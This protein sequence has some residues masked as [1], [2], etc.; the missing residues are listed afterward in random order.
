MILLIQGL[1]DVEYKNKA[2]KDVSGL[3]V[4]GVITEE[5][6]P[7]PKLTGQ[8]T[9]EQYFSGKRSCDYETGQEYELKFVVKKFNGEYHAYPDDLVLVD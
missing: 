3:T 2:G 7:R 1:E 4:Y 5:D 6:Y 9:F 8:R